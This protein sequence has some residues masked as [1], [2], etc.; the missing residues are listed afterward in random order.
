[1]NFI[2]TFKIHRLPSDENLSLIILYILPHLPSL[3]R[4]V[5]PDTEVFQGMSLNTAEASRIESISL[6]ISK[7]AQISRRITEWDV[8]LSEGTDYEAI[9]FSNPSAIRCLTATTVSDEHFRLLGPEEEETEDSESTLSKQLALCPSLEALTLN[10]QLESSLPA[11]QLCHPDSLSLDYLFR[12]T[13]TFL[14]LS[15]SI[16]RHPE[17]TSSDTSL[18]RFASSFPSLRHLRLSGLQTPNVPLAPL[19]FPRL[20]HL[21]LLEVPH[22]DAFT[23]FLVNKIMP[24]LEVLE[25]GFQRRFDLNEMAT[26]E[27]I[28]PSFVETL[29]RYRVTLKSFHIHHY[30]GFFTKDLEILKRSVNCQVHVSWPE[31]GGEAH[32]A[33][34]SQNQPDRDPAAMSGMSHAIREVGRWALESVDKLEQQRDVKGMANLWKEVSGLAEYKKWMQD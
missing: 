1:M 13:L 30:L 8:E 20:V 16:D 34:N 21:E 9:V 32:Y 31:G 14:S 28:V 29:D 4:L 6:M 19:I 24:S 33:G 5:V 7:L 12:P 3:R 25:L 27:E 23:D 2:T 11:Y 17:I 15:A 26:K 18:V 10:F 22:L